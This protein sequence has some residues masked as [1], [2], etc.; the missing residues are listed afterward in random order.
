MFEALHHGWPVVGGQ[1]RDQAGRSTPVGT[2]VRPGW[3]AAPSDWTI[4]RTSPITPFPK[5]ANH[6]RDWHPNHQR[7][8]EDGQ[9]KDANAHSFCSFQ[10]MWHHLGLVAGRGTE[11]AVPGLPHRPAVFD[12]TPAATGIGAQSAPRWAGRHAITHLTK[13]GHAP[14][15]VGSLAPPAF[16]LP[17]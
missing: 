9:R 1:Q 8:R 2:G 17:G 12:A 15:L 10:R 14:R 13:E 5:Q 7:H 4:H 11:M 6:V 16:R 3:V